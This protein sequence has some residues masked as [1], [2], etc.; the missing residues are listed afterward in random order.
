M[1][2]IPTARGALPAG[3]GPHA[4]V[5]E[6]IDLSARIDHASTRFPAYWT[7]VQ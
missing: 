3:D 2:P 6:W 1:H 5:A 4:S 7:K